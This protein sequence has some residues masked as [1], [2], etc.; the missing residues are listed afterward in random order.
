MNFAVIAA[1]AACLTFAVVGP[2]LGRTLPPAA[3]VRLLVPAALLAAGGAVFVVATVA[4]TLVGQLAEVAEFGRWSPH[5]LHVL[6]PIPAPVAVAAGALLLAAAGWTVGNAWRTGRALRMAYRLGRALD[7]H[8]GS[9][10]VVVDNPQPDAFTTPG[11]RARIVVTTGM[12]AALDPPGRRVLLAHEQSHRAHR[13]TWWILAAELAATVNPLLHTTARAVRDATER[14]ADEDA[15]RLSDRRLVAA[16]IAQVALLGA[17]PAST[18]MAAATGGRVP[19][20][21]AALLHPP[22]RL[23][24]R[25]LVVLAAVTL[26]VLLG[27]F[28]VE[29]TGEALFEHARTPAAAATAAGWA[30]IR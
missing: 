2:Y 29:R 19:R 25:H 16:P 23:R 11:L 17:R 14:W 1:L 18:T 15:A 4:F 21:V 28:A 27:A 24:A 13:H 22:P 9:P 3:A 30:P 8:S 20:R 26:A 10:V 12:L 5:V 6:D 7:D